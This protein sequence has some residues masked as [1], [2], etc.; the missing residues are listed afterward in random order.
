MREEREKES[1]HVATAPKDESAA[2]T[3]DPRPGENELRVPARP[4]SDQNFAGP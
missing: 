4:R 1:S 2:T 3:A